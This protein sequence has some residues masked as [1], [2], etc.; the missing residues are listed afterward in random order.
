[1][2]C[3][4]VDQGL[5]AVH[6]FP[7]IFN[8]VAAMVMSAGSEWLTVPAA[9]VAGRSYVPGTLMLSASPLA[10]MLKIRNWAPVLAHVP[11]ARAFLGLSRNDTGKPVAI[12]RKPT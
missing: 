1:M 8:G 9:N 7:L 3:G 6:C 5:A 12:E 4:N 2:F 11:S 10:D